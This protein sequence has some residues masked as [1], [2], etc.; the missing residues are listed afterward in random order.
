MNFR[1]NKW[2]K[3]KPA[4]KGSDFLLFFDPKIQYT[5]SRFLGDFQTLAPLFVLQP[6]LI[7]FLNLSKGSLE[8]NKVRGGRIKGTIG[9]SP[10]KANKTLPGDK[11]LIDFSKVLC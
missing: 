8:T 5:F 10:K 1:V 2:S 11:E 6:L 7:T 9:Q 4:P 3:I